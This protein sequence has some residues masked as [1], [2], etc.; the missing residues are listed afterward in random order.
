MNQLIEYTSQLTQGL[1]DISK[2]SKGHFSEPRNFNSY[3][4]SYNCLHC[5]IL[6]VTISTIA[7]ISVACCYCKRANKTPITTPA[8][9]QTPVI[10]KPVPTAVMQDPVR[11]LTPQPER[12]ALLT[13]SQK[14]YDVNDLHQGLS[15]VPK[16]PFFA[17]N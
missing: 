5:F 3:A 15:Q 4:N 17:A 16:S 7:L 13:S 10:Q 1:D 8:V 2:I 14:H 12:I 9:M 6:S 11:I